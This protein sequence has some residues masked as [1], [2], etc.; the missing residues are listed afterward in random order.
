MYAGIPVVV[1]PLLTPPPV[2]T[3]PKPRKPRSKRHR[4]RKKY[5]KRLSDWRSAHEPDD[6][7]YV[8][9][10]RL[11][12]S[13]HV[14]TVVQGLVGGK[15]VNQRARSAVSMSTTAERWAVRL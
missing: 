10:G 5:S 12:M 1:T 13:P 7:V 8:I 4:I 14:W 2:S 15:T 11:V 6:H 9:D 3:H